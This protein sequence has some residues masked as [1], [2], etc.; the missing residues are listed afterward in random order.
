MS[1]YSAPRHRTTPPVEH[2][3]RRR[4]FGS[5]RV[6]ALLSLGIV[7]GLGAVGTLAYWTDD[8]TITSSSFTSGRLDVTLND[9]LA[10]AANNGG[11][12]SDADFKLADM[13]PG[14]SF[15]RTVKVGNAGTVGLT[16][17]A[18]AW[19]S[20]TLESGLRWTVVAGSTASNSGTP[21][22]GNRAGTCSAGGTTT[23]TNVTLGT[24]A[25]TATTVIT[26]KRTIT[27]TAPIF[28][29]VCVIAKL[30]SGAGNA[31]QGT[32]ASATFTFNGTQLGAP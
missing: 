26:P 5:R 30:D 29:N 12:T 4:V 22:A 6:R 11:T 1:T 19:N 10:G 7:A 25:G 21:A 31:L 9:E 14:E 2:R 3:A 23:A 8:A 20:G 32:S 27:A 17:T 24:T 15:A 28:E 18:K 13:I 16:Y